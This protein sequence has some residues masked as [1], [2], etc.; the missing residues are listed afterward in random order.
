MYANQSPFSPMPTFNASGVYRTVGLETGVTAASP[1]QLVMMLF[2]GVQESIAQARG[3]MRSRNIA[4][5]GRAIGRAVRIVEEGLRAALDLEAGGELALDLREL[6]AYIALRLTRAN[7]ENDEAA[8]DE[9]Q[10]LIEPLASAWAAIG[11]RDA[12]V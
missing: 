7:L 9:C 8:L 2:E 5:K 11:T 10:R 6:Y 4:V 3:A 1:H 12:K